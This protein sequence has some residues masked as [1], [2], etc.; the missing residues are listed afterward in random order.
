L[1]KILVALLS[2]LIFCPAKTQALQQQKKA[3]HAPLV[4]SAFDIRSLSLNKVRQPL[5]QTSPLK[6]IEILESQLNIRKGEFESAVDFER[7]FAKAVDSPVVGSLRP[8]DVFAF[9]LPVEKFESYKQSYIAYRYDPESSIVYFYARPMYEQI[10]GIGHPLPMGE[11]RDIYTL[12]VDEKNERGSYLGSNAFGST[13]TVSK[14][15][16][17]RYAL[18]FLHTIFLG[19]DFNSLT[20]TIS[21]PKPIASIPMESAKAAKELPRLRAYFIFQPAPPFVLYSYESRK[22]TLDSPVDE[23]I[24][25]KF[26]FGRI[27]GFVIHS[28]ISGEILMRAP[29]DFGQLA[30]P[31]PLIKL[32][33][34][35][36]SSPE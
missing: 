13:A 10:N 21:V 19:A 26:L 8:M 30:E 20:Y 23:V 31:A 36:A 4:N 18:A 24:N 17:T 16:K 5:P 3:S 1:K 6:L 11:S 9:N 14:I 32:D 28:G 15:R 29:F 35:G 34:Y 12:P 27:V 2:P 7:R 25:S 33:E 22:P